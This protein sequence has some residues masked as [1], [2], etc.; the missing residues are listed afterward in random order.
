MKIVP[1]SAPALRMGI[2]TQRGCASVR[3]GTAESFAILATVLL[4]KNAQ[5]DA[6]G[7]PHATR[8]ADAVAMGLAR[9]IPAIWVTVVL[10]VS[11]HLQDTHMTWLVQTLEV[12]SIVFHWMAKLFVIKNPPAVGRAFVRRVHSAS[13]CMKA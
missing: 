4:A 2:V 1:R 7:V 13:V 5:Q 8:T 11:F 9:A 12:T 3:L 6:A 10:N